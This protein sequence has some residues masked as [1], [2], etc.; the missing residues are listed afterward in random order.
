MIVKYWSDYA[1]LIRLASEAGL[2][3]QEV[4]EIL[5][6]DRFAAEVRRDEM[7]AKAAGNSTRSKHLSTQLF[8]ARLYRHTS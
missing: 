5:L 6:T 7:E 2:A 8:M 1:V 4:Q 3:A